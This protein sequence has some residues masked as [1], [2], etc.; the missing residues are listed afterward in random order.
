[1]H[2][3]FVHEG[4]P[5]EAWT[6]VDEITDPTQEKPKT[7]GSSSQEIHCLQDSQ[8]QQRQQ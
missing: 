8:P 5:K 7:K 6:T 1:M 2:S 4:M 3:R